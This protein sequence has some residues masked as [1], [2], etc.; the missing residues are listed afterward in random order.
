MQLFRLE[1]QCKINVPV[2]LHAGSKHS[3]GVHVTSVPED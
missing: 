3:Q 1:E 2:R